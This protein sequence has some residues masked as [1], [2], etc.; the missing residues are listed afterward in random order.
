MVSIKRAIYFAL[1]TAEILIKI[2]PSYE[3]SGRFNEN[4]NINGKCRHGANN[5][6][7]TFFSIKIFSKYLKEKPKKRCFAKLCATFWHQFNREKICLTRS[8]ILFGNS[9]NC[10]KY[11]KLLNLTRLWCFI[12]QQKIFAPLR[13]AIAKKTS[14]CK[15]LSKA[16]KNNVF[17]YILHFRNS[18]R[19]ISRQETQRISMKTT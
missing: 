11:Q 6:I 4:E 13:D 14:A 1:K 5:E 17:V 8:L 19:R 10:K 2:P 15:F 18:S 9:A 12:M 7:I 3:D 16:V